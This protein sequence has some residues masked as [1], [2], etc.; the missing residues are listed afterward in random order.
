MIFK[1]RTTRYNNLKAEYDQILLQEV[2]HARKDYHQA[3][4]SETALVDSRVNG[5]MVQAQ[6]A[7]KKARFTYLYKE[8]KRRKTVANGPRLYHQSDE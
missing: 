6:T 4:D 7:L 1:K 3:Q 8:A 2:D 5:H